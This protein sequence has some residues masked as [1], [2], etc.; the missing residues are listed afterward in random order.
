[1]A[2]RCD[3]LTSITTTN[4]VLSVIVLVAA[5][6][7]AVA[8]WRGARIAHEA[9]L[10]FL[11]FMVMERVYSPQYTLWVLIY[12]LLDD[13]ELWTIVALSLIGLIEYGSAAIHIQLVHSDPRTLAILGWYEQHI[14]YAQQGLRL[15]G[16][17][18]I[19]GAMLARQLRNGGISERVPPA[20]GE[21]PV[22]AAVVP[23]PGEI[24]RSGRLLGPKRTISVS[25]AGHG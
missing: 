18:A 3:G 14:M 4:L 11:A 13:W 9:A 5:A 7:A 1:M 20:A 21:E 6:A 25:D 16:S 15:L 22:R 2:A 23:Q 8:I 10:V 17:I 24:V 19:G 12:A